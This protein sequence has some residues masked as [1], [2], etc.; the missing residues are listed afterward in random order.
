MYYL[1]TAHLQH[2]WWYTSCHEDQHHSTRERAWNTIP[3]LPRPFKNLYGYTLRSRLRIPTNSACQC[4]YDRV[5]DV[6]RA[7]ARAV[8]KCH[9]DDGVITV[10]LP[11]NLRCKVFTTYDVDNLDRHNKGWVSWHCF[12][13]TKPSVK[14]KSRRAASCYSS[15]LLWQIC[16]RTSKLIMLSYIQLSWVT[17]MCLYLEA[18]SA[19]FDHLIVLCRE[20]R[21]MTNCGWYMPT[22][23]YSTTLFQRMKSSHGQCTTLGSRMTTCW[24]HRQ[25]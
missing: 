18:S 19:K 4:H 5:M 14:G 7:I 16:A 2:I 17:I 9:A 13:C 22:R 6:K 11:T 12:E 25:S 1:T 15:E 20:P 21:W 3:G 8:C 23:C 24:N 10:V